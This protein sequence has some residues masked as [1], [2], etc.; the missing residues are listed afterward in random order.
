[1]SAASKYKL[2][3]SEITAL[4]TTREVLIPMGDADGQDQLGCPPAHNAH[5]HHKYQHIRDALPGV[6]KTLDDHIISTAQDCGG[7]ADQHGDQKHHAVAANPMM[8]EILA[9]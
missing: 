8:T 2:E 5:G 4:R 7:R 1:M 6:H 9:P 3:R